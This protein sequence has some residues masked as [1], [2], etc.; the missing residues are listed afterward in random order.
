LQQAYLPCSPPSRIVAFT[1]RMNKTTGTASRKDYWCEGKITALFRCGDN[2]VF[3]LNYIAP[4]FHKWLNGIVFRMKQLSIWS[5]K[6]VLLSLCTKSNFRNAFISPSRRTSFIFRSL[7]GANI[8]YSAWVQRFDFFKTTGN[9][10]KVSDLMYC[11]FTMQTPRPCSE[12]L[13]DNGEPVRH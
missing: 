1:Q 13:R 6:T 3:L 10:Q 2:V 9:S 5:V 8:L 12:S 4:N 11:L 7:N